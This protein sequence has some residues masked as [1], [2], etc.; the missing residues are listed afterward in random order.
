MICKNLVPCF[1]QLFVLEVYSVIPFNIHQLV[2]IS[3]NFEAKNLHNQ[4]SLETAKVQ[5]YT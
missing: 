3:M 2:A 4:N 5:T 1:T